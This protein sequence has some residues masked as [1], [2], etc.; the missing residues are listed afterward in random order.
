MSFFRTEKGQELIEFLGLPLGIPSGV[1]DRTLF[2]GEENLQTFKSKWNG[3]VQEALNTVAGVSIGVDY[4]YEDSSR[5]LKLDVTTVTQRPISGELRLIV[6]I[7]ENKL[8]DKQA[9]ATGDGVDPEFEHNHILRDII[10]PVAGELLATGAAG[11]T[12]FTNSI[13]YT[14]PED[15]DD[16]GWWKVPNLEVVVY[17]VNNDGD[18]KEVLQ[19]KGLHF[20]E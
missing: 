13:T 2:P 19:A 10:T 12:A 6:M 17:V 16:L 11:Q 5:E 8:I 18:N 7:V 1:V 4:A 3:L 14:I 20:V 15:E 9:V